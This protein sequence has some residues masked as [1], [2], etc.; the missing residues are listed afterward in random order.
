MW[1][2]DYCLSQERYPHE[3]TSSSSW[4]QGRSSHLRGALVMAYEMWEDYQGEDS[5]V[6]IRWLLFGKTK[7]W[8]KESVGVCGK[9]IPQM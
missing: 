2:S 1:A 8:V 9:I 7:D 6:G 5:S 4:H 3:C